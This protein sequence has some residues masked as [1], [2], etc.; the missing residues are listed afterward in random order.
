MVPI[1]NRHQLGLSNLPY[2][3]HMQ[4]SMENGFKILS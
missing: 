4:S 3:V 1:A 2:F